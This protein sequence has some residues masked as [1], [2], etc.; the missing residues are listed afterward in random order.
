MTRFAAAILF[1]VACYSP[2]LGQVKTDRIRVAENVMQGMLV[3][4][5]DPQPPSGD[6]ANIHGEVVF[7]AVIGKEGSIESLQAVSGHPILI[8]PAIN[9]VKQWKYKPFL[10][11]GEP[12]R[13]ETTIRVNF[14][15]DDGNPQK[16]QSAK[17]K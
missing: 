11:N 3:K 12:V 8:P 6:A 4:K 5:V 10:L 14:P 1:V 16:P 17:E 2:A 9:A 15:A 7:K 13:V